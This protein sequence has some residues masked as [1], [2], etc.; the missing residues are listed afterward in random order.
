LR[1]GVLRSF[2]IDA[3]RRTRGGTQK[4]SHALFES[5]LVALEDV[6]AAIAGLNARWDVRK[7][8]CGGFAE[9]C[10]Q[11]HAKAFEKGDEGF[12]DFP[13]DGWH[14]ALL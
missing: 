6:D 4:A 1:F 12:P 7:A 5:V 8:L 9:H 2:D 3:I 11:R 13:N 10:P 14:R